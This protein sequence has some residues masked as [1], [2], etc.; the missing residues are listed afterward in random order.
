MKRR[1]GRG[2]GAIYRRKDGQW[3][4]SVTIGY[5]EQGRRRRRT[6]YGATKGA[7]VEK[8]AKTQSAIATGT[9]AEVQRITLAQFLERWQ[10]RLTIAT[11]ST[12]AYS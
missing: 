7:V 8:L 1:R 5:D 4:A 9:L 3:C 6:L 11:K 12:F 2:E 10:Q